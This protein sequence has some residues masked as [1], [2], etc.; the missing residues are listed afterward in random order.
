MIYNLQF[1]PLALKEWE[2]LD[3][4]VRAQFKKKLME[5]L[6]QPRVP[7]ASLSGGVDLYKIKLASVGYRLVYKV[8]DD[9]VTVYVLSVDKR[10][11]SAAYKKGLK[12]DT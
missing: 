5:R 12:R 10:E 6:E 11:G 2:K 3:A 7:S 4:S 1:H 9:T 8:I